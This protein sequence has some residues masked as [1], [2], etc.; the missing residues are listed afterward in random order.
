VIDQDRTNGGEM[1]S[2]QAAVISTDP[3]CLEAVRAALSELPDVELGLELSVP[4]TEIA[5]PQ[6]ERLRRLEPAVILL[7]LESDPRVG[8]KFAQFLL[9]E[10][11]TPAMIGAGSDLSPELL[12]AAMQAGIV[13]FLP[14]PLSPEDLREALERL[15]RK[16]GRKTREELDHEPGKVLAV[17][18][19]KG[20]AGSTTFATNLAVEVHRLSRRKTLLV[21]LDLEL[22]ETALLLGME[23][24]FSIV[25]LVRNFHRVDAGLLASY[26]E[27]HES[28]VELLSAP[29]QPTDPED[30]RAERVAQ[31]L[32]FLRERYDYVVVDT[33]K[34]FSSI[35]LTGIEESDELFFLTTA[36][37]QSLRN[38]TRCLPLLRRISERKEKG[39]LKL[40]VNR[41]D[42]RQIISLDEVEKTLGLEVYATLHNDYR[43]VMESIN[44][45]RPSVMDGRS[46]YAQ[47]VRSIA[48]REV[49]IE[50]GDA[51]QGRGM[52]SRVL[53]A[54]RG[55][56]PTGLRE[57]PEPTVKTSG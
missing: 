36:D 52:M 22:G 40:I 43:S 51:R 25:D 13:E 12:L 14:K 29:F 8:L 7:D 31:I 17:F 16:T 39:W 21:D 20:G 1:R 15:W 33:P 23:P 6:L 47:D 56:R 9:D 48:A 55:D 19:A 11:Y 53:G 35:A 26:I 41:F 4:F 44:E 28:G 49:G 5:D 45:G 24:K 37:L 3:A 57:S 42:P 30:V 18:G 50:A 54:L 38:V 32:A 10:G 27:R 34:T 2:V 46:A